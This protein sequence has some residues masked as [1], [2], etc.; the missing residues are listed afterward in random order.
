LC[1]LL[2]DIEAAVMAMAIAAHIPNWRAG[3]LQ[4]MITLLF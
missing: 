1:G 3:F 2:E 4:C